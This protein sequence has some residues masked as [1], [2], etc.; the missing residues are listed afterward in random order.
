MPH[1]IEELGGIKDK[2]LSQKAMEYIRVVI[3]HWMVNFFISIEKISFVYIYIFYNSFSSVL[4][5]KENIP[6][7]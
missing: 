6:F 3:W 2:I 1:A 7:K 5:V 4:H